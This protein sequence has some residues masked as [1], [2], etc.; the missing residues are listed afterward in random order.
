MKI[1]E[2]SIDL[3]KYLSE[4]VDSLHGQ[5]VLELGCGAAL[6]GIFCLKKGQVSDLHLQDF[7]PE[8][9]DHI[10]KPNLHLNQGS[11]NNEIASQVRLFSGDWSDFLDKMSKESMKYDLILTSETIYE[12]ANYYKLLSIFDQ[13]LQS[14]G[15]ILLAAKIHYFGVGGGLRS[16]EKCLQSKWTF[17]T[18]FENNDTVK[19]EIIEIRRKN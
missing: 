12:E 7:N 6:P 8:V 3:V 11:Q 18:V 16:F 17:R 14:N 13:L 1:W 4:S 15:S 9:I 10:T 19:R 2:C 5:K